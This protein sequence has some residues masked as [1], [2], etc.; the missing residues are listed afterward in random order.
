MPTLRAEREC[1]EHVPGSER[2]VKARSQAGRHRLTPDCHVRQVPGAAFSPAG[3]LAQRELTLRQETVQL[4]TEIRHLD[5]IAVA[6]YIP[7]S[8][9]SSGIQETLSRYPGRVVD[10]Q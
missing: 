1:R 6:W 8:P 5:P 3:S 10:C 7:V 2:T 4:I 9:Q